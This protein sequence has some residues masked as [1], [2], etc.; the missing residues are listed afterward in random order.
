MSEIVSF[1]NSASC[2]CC[3]QTSGDAIPWYEHDE[4]TQQPI[5]WFC[6]SCG[7]IVFT[8]YPFLNKE[9]ARG[10]AQEERFRTQIVK[11]G[12]IKLGVDAKDFYPQEVVMQRTYGWTMEEA[13]RPLTSS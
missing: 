7:D 5:G 2:C 10:R 3:F 4:E 1:R 9:T 6:W 13:L 12:R 8:R 11:M